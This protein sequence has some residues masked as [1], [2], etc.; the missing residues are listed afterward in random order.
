M[1]R[2]REVWGAA[3]TGERLLLAAGFAYLVWPL[4]FVPEALFGLVGLTDDL[5][6]LALLGSLYG[7][8]RKRLL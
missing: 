2:L 5:A 7:R 4:D 3:T 6:A 8:I 1:A